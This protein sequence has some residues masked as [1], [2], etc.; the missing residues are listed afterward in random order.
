MTTHK[1]TFE[2]ELL[3]GRNETVV[4]IEVEYSIDIANG[5]Q[6]EILS[7]KGVTHTTRDEDDWIYD[8]ACR[9]ADDDMAE[10]EAKYAADHLDAMERDNPERY[11]MLQHEWSS[12]Q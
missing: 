7:V 10:W 12:E 5:G 9:Y 4:P 2:A 6:V 3:R 8:L 11:A 1:F